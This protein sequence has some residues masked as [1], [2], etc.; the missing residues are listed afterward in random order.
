MIID[1]PLVPARL[2]MGG[3]SRGGCAG[4]NALESLELVFPEERE[5]LG[6]LMSRWGP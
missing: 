1:T 6:V 2:V 4:K 3:Y 5:A